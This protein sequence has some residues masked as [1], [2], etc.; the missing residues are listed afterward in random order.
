MD[1]GSITSASS[2]IKSAIDIAKALV[3]LKSIADVETVAIQLREKISTAQAAMI[4][5]QSE[6]SAM[7]QR[8]SDLEKE[9]SKLETWST[10]KQRYQLTDLWNTGVVAYALKESMCNA[11]PPHYLCTKCYED[12]RKSILGLQK[13]RKN[14]RMMLVCHTC[15][16]EFHSNYSRNLPMNYVK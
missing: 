10:E 3:Q 1:I 4:K 16:S 9:V 5:A 11:E 2:S 8:I 6:Q 7:V 14:L 13:N 12:G 15:G